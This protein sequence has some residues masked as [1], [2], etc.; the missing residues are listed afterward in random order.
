MTPRASVV[1]PARDARATLPRTLQAIADQDVDEDY[2]VIVIDDGSRDDTAAAARAAPG[3]VHVVRQE[4]AGPAA[5][6]NR[7]AAEARGT[8]LAFC[9][10]DVYPTR[11]WLRA[12][13]AALRRAHLVQGMV[14]P[15]PAAELG[16]FDRTIWVTR[17]TSLWEAANL[18][19][20]GELFA[21]LGGFSDGIKPARGKM[22]AED[23]WFGHLARQRGASVAFC[24][25]AL[26]HHAVFERGAAAYASERWRRRFFPEIVAVAPELR[27]TFLYRRWFLDARSAR[28]DLALLGGGAA[29]AARTPLPLLVALPYA[30]ALRGHARRGRPTPSSTIAVACVDLIADAVSLAAMA[31]GSAR[32]RAVVL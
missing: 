14:L 30:R 9:D 22:L 8:A 31:R 4:Q 13:L 25:A 29:L 11:G 23:V 28:F 15:D 18:F 10:A 5:A 6:R 7:G 27:A 12:G 24:A 21:R 16:P 2:E 20:T 32:A 1:V 3:A 17:L 19:V 26:A